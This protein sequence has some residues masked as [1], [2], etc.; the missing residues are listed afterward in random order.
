MEWP[1]VGSLHRESSRIVTQADR[2]VALEAAVL[3]HARTAYALAHWLTR[4]V[5]DAED[6]VQEAWLRAF[7]YFDGLR[8][9]D[10]RSWF[11]AID[12]NCFHRW[13]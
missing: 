9:D 6:G 8:G 5:H 13:P 10:A 12:R 11:L 3:P 4:D 2:A 7:Q 1:P